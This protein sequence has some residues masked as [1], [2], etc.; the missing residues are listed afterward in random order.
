M[1]ITECHIGRMLN[2]SWQIKRAL[3]DT[4]SNPVIDD[5]HAAIMKAGA[6]G[7]KLCGAGGGGFFLV[8][9][10]PDAIP[11]IQAAVHPAASIPIAMDVAGTRVVL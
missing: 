1:D 2:E 3:S 6:H 8:L 11:R 10:D 4:I 9:A 7:A 5:L